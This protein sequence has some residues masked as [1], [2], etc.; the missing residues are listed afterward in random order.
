MFDQ[1]LLLSPFIHQDAPMYRPGG[2]GWIATG[3]PRIIGLSF[4]NH[5]GITQLNSLPV[6]AFALTSEAQK[7]L[8]PSYSYSLAMNFRPQ[9]DYRTNIAAVMQPLQVLVGEDDEVFF[10][11]QFATVFEQAGKHVPAIVL[12]KLGHIDMTL[13]PSAFDAVIASMGSF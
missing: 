3:V 13:E 8:T 11:E 10:A 5:L 6:I 1:Y 9:N 4:L 12:P 2:G 7:S